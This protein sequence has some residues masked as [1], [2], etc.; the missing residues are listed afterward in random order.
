MKLNSSSSVRST[1]SWL[2]P[3]SNAKITI[4]NTLIISLEIAVVAAIANAIISSNSR[5]RIHSN[6]KP[7]ILLVA[8]LANTKMMQKTLTETLAHG[9]SSESTL[10]ELSMNTNVTGFKLK[11]LCVFMLCTHEAS[12]L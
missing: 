12:A 10:R 6:I 3:S 11:N 7:N 1:L 8:H 5:S 9:Y 2:W 4:Q